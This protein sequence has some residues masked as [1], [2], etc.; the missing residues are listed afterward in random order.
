MENKFNQ[1]ESILVIRQMIDQAKGDLQD[2]TAKYFILWGYIV[3]VTC[4]I[5]YASFTFSSFGHNNMNSLLIWGVPS[6][7]GLAISLYFAWQDNKRLIVKTYIVILVSRIWF[8]FM[9]LACLIGFCLAGPMAMLIYPAIGFL[10][11]FALFLTACAFRLKWMYISVA[12]CFVCL[13]LYRLL[14]V[15]LYP[16][17][18]AIMLTSGMI[19]PGHII[20]N[21]TKRNVQRT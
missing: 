18:M 10:F 1:E 5:H 19:V 6:F 17:L 11:T 13:I 12:I 3:V 15:S 21:K 14:G 4:L 16:L 8:G 7:I 2:G 9:V 20:N